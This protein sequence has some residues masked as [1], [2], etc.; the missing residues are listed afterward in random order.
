[1]PIAQTFDLIENKTLSSGTTQVS[2]TSIPQTYT[3]LFVTTDARYTNNVG[4]A[5]II[6]FNNSGINVNV[7]GLRM[8]NGG[9]SISLQ[10]TNGDISFAPND[11]SPQ[12]GAMH[13]INIYNYT[14]TNMF[15]QYTVFHNVGANTTDGSLASV[16]FMAGSYRVSGT[17]ISRIDFYGAGG[18]DGI[19]ATG[20]KFA[21]WGI[22]EA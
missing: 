19:F 13:K 17:A 4:Y 8:V 3:D 14:S 9:A 21:L 18:G 16:S 2:F 20:S 6:G 22:K 15:K 1:M 11:Q 10:E 5:G 12:S 7:S